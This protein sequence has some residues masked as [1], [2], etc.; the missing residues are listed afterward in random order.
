LYFIN[1]GSV[2]IFFLLSSLGLTCSFFS[3]A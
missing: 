1:F 2:V 3:I